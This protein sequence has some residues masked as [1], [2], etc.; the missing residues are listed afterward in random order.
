MLSADRI[1]ELLGQITLDFVH[2]PSPMRGFSCAGQV[3]FSGE[4]DAAPQC[5]LG[6][7]PHANER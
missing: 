6:G 4:R 1:E 5:H 7:A 2:V 3:L